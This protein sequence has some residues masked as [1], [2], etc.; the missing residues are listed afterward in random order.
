MMPSI[1]RLRQFVVRATALADSGRLANMP[2]PALRDA[3]Q[4]LVGSDDWLPE[5]FD[6]PH[7]AHYQQFLLHCDPCERFCLVSFVWGPGQFTPVHDH[8]VWGYVG[9]LRGA[10][11]SQRYL[12][13]PE[14]RYIASGPAERL[15]PGEVQELSPRDGD[16]HKV[17]NAY[18]DRP[19]VSIHMY[20]GNIGA[21]RRHVYDTATGRVKQFVS[22]YSS[23]HVPNLW[24]RSA[25]IRTA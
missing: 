21:I 15:E 6:Q 18:N 3:F 14:G 22:G 16:V 10:E 24:D 12:V 9:V 4:A 23:A 19:S 7:P 11:M 13:D 20:G 17:W 2:P 5:G 25:Q 8:T 1:D